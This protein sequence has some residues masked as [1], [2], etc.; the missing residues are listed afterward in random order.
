MDIISNKSNVS[1][2]D[3]PKY[4]RY[5]GKQGEE[6]YMDLETERGVVISTGKSDIK[7]PTPALVKGRERCRYNL[8]ML[9]LHKP[10][11]SP[12]AKSYPWN[13]D[14]VAW[15]CAAS[16]RLLRGTDHQGESVLK[17]PQKLRDNATWLLYS[18]WEYV[19]K[20]SDRRINF[21]KLVMVGD[22][23]GSAEYFRY[24][25][26]NKMHDPIS[27]TEMH[28]FVTNL[29]SLIY[30][31]DIPKVLQLENT[32]LKFLRCMFYQEGVSRNHISQYK[33]DGAGFKNVFAHVDCANDVVNELPYSEKV[34][35][36]SKSEFPYI[37]PSF[38]STQNGHLLGVSD[39]FREFLPLL[40]RKNMRL[41]LALKGVLKGIL[42][43]WTEG[44]L[45]QTC[46][47][48]YGPP[49]SG[50]SELVKVLSMFCAP[51][52][53]KVFQRHHSQ[54]T[55][56]DVAGTKLLVVNDVSNIRPGDT[57]GF[58]PLLGRD[59]MSY[60]VKY[61]TVVPQVKPKCQVVMISNFP[62]E[63]FKVL[64]ES[65]IDNKIIAIGLGDE[66][67][68]TENTRIPDFSERC[69]E[70]INELF[71][72]AVYGRHEYLKHHV[73]AEYYQ[74]QRIASGASKGAGLHAFAVEMLQYLPRNNRN[75]DIE[76]FLPAKDLRTV[77]TQY[78]D[79]TGDEELTHLLAGRTSNPALCKDLIGIL[80]SAYGT[81]C[82]YGRYSKS[83]GARPY[84]IFYITPKP[85]SGT[86]DSG[87]Q[88]VKATIVEDK[89]QIEDLLLS[90][91]RVVRMA[92]HF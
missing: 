20:C 82:Y 88:E 67:I 58:K 56:A 31:D 1:G 73:R 62:P 28:R 15:S 5:I 41:G 10:L 49:S 24:S 16:I 79:E 76:S 47:Y 89:Y 51:G 3:L 59:L 85:A 45:Y 34:L 44:D 52:E 48:L 75:G 14:L 13:D 87:F 46:L 54:F 72:W 32:R 39:R 23:F 80:N 64:R 11:R 22:A 57:D 65:G 81:D 37:K 35:C 84:G 38:I 17:R 26:K 90:S 91:P 7:I 19:S 18:F 63:H 2:C 8:Y 53:M 33:Y 30:G 21:D 68:L 50:K 12:S 40:V 42:G 61:Q 86:I 66:S 43:A 25:R 27:K 69:K 6:S 78:A 77:I 60:Q 74:E 4:V 83:K 9:L 36:T 29:V 55:L 71:N 92:P 70:Q